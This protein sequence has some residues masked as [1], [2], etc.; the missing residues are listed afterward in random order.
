MITVSPHVF[1][2]VKIKVKVKVKLPLRLTK[3]HAVDTYP[4]LK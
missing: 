4:L 2:N 1:L 3:Y